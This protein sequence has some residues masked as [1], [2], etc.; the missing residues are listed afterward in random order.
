MASN[1]GGRRAGMIRA[2]GAVVWRGDETAP[3]V[4]LVHRPKYRDWTFPKGKLKAGEHVIAGALREVAEETGLRIVLGRAL[5]PVHYLKGLRLK[6]VDY[7]LARATGGSAGGEGRGDG[8]EVDEVVWLP[9]AEAGRRLTYGWDGKMLRALAGAPLTTTP[10]LFVRH[11]LAGSRQEWE[12]DD[13][14]RPLDERGKAQARALAT[15]LGGYRPEVLI[16][17][18]SARCTQT[19]QPYADRHGMEIVTDKALSE[20]GYDPREAGRLLGELL[21]AGRPAALCSHGK[22]LPELLPMAYGHRLADPHIAKG[23]LAVLHRAGGRT[24]SFER[25][26]S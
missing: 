15:V 2:A 11:G 18:H 9:L 22:V 8:D 26:V 24:V 12:G 10:L 25:Y 6:R 20:S 7:W 13:D 21:A 23:G 16:S 3:E 5:P 14:L 4:A 17:S 1:D 19:L